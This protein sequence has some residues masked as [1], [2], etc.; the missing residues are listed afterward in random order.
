LRALGVA[1]TKPS[2]LTPGLQPIGET[3]PGYESTSHIAFFAPAKTPP[4]I[5]ERLN[6]EIVQAVHRPQVKEMLF[7]GGVEPVG[8]TAKAL[9]EYVDMDIDRIRKMLKAANV[10]TRN[11]H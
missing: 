8:S 2:A 4:S 3:V 1:S 11:V 9:G 5:I 6:Q 7:K 10:D